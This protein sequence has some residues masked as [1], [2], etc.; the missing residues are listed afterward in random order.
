[1]VQGKIIYG[2]AGITIGGKRKTGIFVELDSRSLL[3]VHT[4]G[5]YGTPVAVIRDRRVRSVAVT[6]NRRKS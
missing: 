4:K 6:G 3:E 2:G 1:M 5:L